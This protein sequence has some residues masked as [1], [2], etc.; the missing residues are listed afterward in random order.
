MAAVATVATAA[1]A[2]AAAYWMGAWPRTRAGCL[3]LGMQR[4]CR[5]AR[6]DRRR[7]G[8]RSA[9][10]RRGRHVSGGT[11]RTRRV[12]CRPRMAS[13]RRHRSRRRAAAAWRPAKQSCGWSTAE[14][15]AAARA[16]M[17]GA[18]GRCRCYSSRLWRCPPADGR[19]IGALMHWDG[20][21]VLESKCLIFD[22]VAAAS[23][24]PAA[25]LC[26][27]S[28]CDPDL[29]PCRD[30]NASCGRKESTK[31]TNKSAAAPCSNGWDQRAS[32]AGLAV[33]R[34]AVIA[35][36]RN[37]AL[38]TPCLIQG[39]PR[40]VAGWR[41]TV[42]V[43]V[44]LSIRAPP[45]RVTLADVSAEGLRIVRAFLI[46]SPAVRGHRWTSL[47]WLG[48]Q[49]VRLGFPVH[50]GRHC[51]SP[52]ASTADRPRHRHRP[53]FR[54]LIRVHSN[55]RQWQRGKRGPPRPPGRF[56]SVGWQSSAGESVRQS[57]VTTNHHI[58]S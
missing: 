23:R 55:G 33:Q 31:S 16:G 39:T 57:L 51:P 15:S 14:G 45:Q 35:W 38:V 22:D 25:K 37:R 58:N 34:M 26:T 3:P 10:R 42:I 47:R 36:S 12:R 9:G 4:C 32:S 19:C 53:A 18:R 48:P 40:D 43:A 44:P 52:S 21:A 11:R 5:R 49:L 13:C 6:A 20:N 29:R 7:V 46:L 17:R 41:L 54:Q 28:V 24:A 1:A 56:Q 30:S 50:C 27:A 8:G 2:A